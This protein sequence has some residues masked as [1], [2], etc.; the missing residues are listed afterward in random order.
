M[1][2]ALVC[3]FLAILVLGSC[4]NKQKIV[5]TWADIEGQTWVFSAD[6][7]LTYENTDGDYREYNYNIADKKLPFYLIGN[8]SGIETLQ[9]YDISIS[10]DGKTLM[11]TGGANVDG[12]S[13]AGLGWSKNQ[14]TKK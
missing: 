5:G 7:K 1:K 9:V 11:L 2:K 12:W 3:L 4:S 10:G 13:V 8:Y 6:G 14:L